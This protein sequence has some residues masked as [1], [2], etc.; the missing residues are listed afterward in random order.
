MN[1]STIKSMAS[2]PISNATQSLFMW[3][4]GG[5]VL[6]GEREGGSWILARAWLA[7]DR[8][9]HVR[10]WSFAQPIPFSGQVRRLVM[11]ANGD[12][13]HARDEG[14]RALSWAESTS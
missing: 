2:G 4:G 3:R 9:E 12:F 6:F 13:D 8:L 10:R 14:R 11:E 7:G 5:I 1:E